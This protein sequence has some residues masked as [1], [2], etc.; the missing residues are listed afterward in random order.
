MAC[1]LDVEITLGVNGIYIQLY[2]ERYNRK[3]LQQDTSIL[4]QSLSYTYICFSKC[5]VCFIPSY[6]SIGFTTLCA[7]VYVVRKETNKVCDWAAHIRTYNAY[8]DLEYLMQN[9]SMHLGHTSTSRTTHTVMSFNY[10]CCLAMNV[11]LLHLQS[12]ILILLIYLFISLSFSLSLSLSFFLSL[13]CPLITL[14]VFSLSVS[15]LHIICEG[16]SLGHK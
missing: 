9:V 15:F 3:I 5:T 14:L 11:Q 13:F 4:S 12:L 6:V 1:F 10:S 16:C 8:V 2:H 7:C